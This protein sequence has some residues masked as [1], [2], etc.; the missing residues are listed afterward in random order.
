[1]THLSR[2]I[3]CILVTVAVVV[4]QS[5]AAHAELSSSTPR[6]GSVVKSLPNRVTLELSEAVKKPAFVVV[7]DESGKRI[8]SDTVRV[9]GRTVSSAIADRAGRGRFT[10][11]YRLVSSDAHV[12][13]GTL[14]FSVPRGSAFATPSPSAAAPTSISGESVSSKSRDSVS[15]TAG[16]VFILVALVVMTGLSVL[17]LLRLTSRAG[18]D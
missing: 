7:S 10:I 12:V 2:T 16:I 4:P 13:S 6:D 5:A 3:A 14:K 11:S 17:I 8:N 15:D 9:S 1:M 18:K